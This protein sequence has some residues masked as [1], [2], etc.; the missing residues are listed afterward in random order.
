[1]TAESGLIHKGNRDSEP[2]PL[3]GEQYQA[4]AIWN[5]CEGVFTCS[6]FHRRSEAVESLR[7]TPFDGG[8]VVPVTITVDLPE[9]WSDRHDREQMENQ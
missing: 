4:W 7:S 9:K 5:R 8:R 3:L 6:V 1:M 2:L